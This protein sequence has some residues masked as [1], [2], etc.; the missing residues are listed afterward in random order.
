MKI[1]DLETPALVVQQ[2][3]L[4]RNLSRM[5]MLLA[6]KKPKLRPHYK[7]HKSPHIAAM[8][9]AAGAK[10]ITCSKLSEAIDLA[11]HGIH[12]ILIANQ[13]VQPQK[14]A[15]LAYLA[16]KCHLTVCVDD[17]D[18]ARALSHA[19]T[20]AGTTIHCYIELELGMHRCG[21]DDFEE[22][23]RLAQTIDGLPGLSY[24]G[25]QA[26][27]GNLSHE[28]DKNLREVT[29]AENEQRLRELIHYLEA[30]GVRSR[31]VSGGSTGTA[32]LKAGSRVYTELQAGSFMLM[33][34]AYDRMHVGFDNALYAVCTVI[35]AGPGRFV[36]DA[37]VK[38]LSPDQD[39]PRVVGFEADAVSLSEEHTSFYGKHDFKVGDTVLVIP[40]HCCATVNL[41]DHLYFVRGGE[42]TP[43][44]EILQKRAVVSRGK[45][46]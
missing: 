16:G 41:Y 26:Y 38:S 43:E 9:I 19:A 22:F 18:N 42:L 10:G 30:R 20:L 8:Q 31:E 25:I 29:V 36:I 6:G 46:Q 37:G 32:Y 11:D 15:K 40:G 4:E 44:T 5:M 35:S 1:R 23:Y 34:C 17:Y 27:A 13:V 45:A 28:Y 39:L 7:T 33:D 21:L 2:D 12:D 14:I 24:D 3:K